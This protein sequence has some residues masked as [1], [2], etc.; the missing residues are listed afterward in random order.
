MSEEKKTAEDY[1]SETALSG[2]R[3]ELNRGLLGSIV[4]PWV[5]NLAEA[6]CSIAAYNYVWL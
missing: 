5:P 1:F 3:N 4:A 2:A 6:A